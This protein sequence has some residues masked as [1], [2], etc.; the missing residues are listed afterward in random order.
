MVYHD[1]GESEHERLKEV[2]LASVQTDE[3]RRELRIME[4]SM[5][6]VHR[7]EGALLALRKALISLLR[8]R[9]GKLP[10]AIERTITATNDVATLD[11]WM[12]RFAK[13][14]SIDDVG[15]KTERRD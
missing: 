12:V 6:D 13:A 1:R 8:E 9:F 5:A 15:I 11:T 3:H 2:V 7:E 14:D 10:R 4:R